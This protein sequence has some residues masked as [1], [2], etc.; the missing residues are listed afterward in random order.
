M[1]SNKYH[2]TK[3]LHLFVWVFCNCLFLY[4]WCR[5]PIC[6]LSV[7]HNYQFFSSSTLLFIRTQ[8]RE[9]RPCFLLEFIMMMSWSSQWLTKAAF[10]RTLCIWCILAL[11]L[12]FCSFLLLCEA[13]FL[14]QEILYSMVNYY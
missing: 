7:C 8:E 14:H 6:I 13:I 10:G 3:D 9:I 4:F 5:I 12:Y 2:L 11:Y 1:K